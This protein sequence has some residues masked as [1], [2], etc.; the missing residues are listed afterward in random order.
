MSPQTSRLLWLFLQGGPKPYSIDNISI[1][2]NVD[3]LK[4]RI[5]QRVKLL[6]HIDPDDLKLCKLNVVVSIDPD[7]SLVQRLEDLGDI[8]AYSRE[9][10]SEETAG[11]LFPEPH[12]E[13]NLHIVV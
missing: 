5:Q 8:H 13:D 1:S 2:D 7:D 12:S 6:H 11:V 4:A 10:S 9:L 3:L